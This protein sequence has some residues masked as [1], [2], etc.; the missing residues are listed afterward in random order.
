MTYF[1]LGHKL[2]SVPPVTRPVALIAAV[3]SAILADVLTLFFI[4]QIGWPVGRPQL[5]RAAAGV[6]AYVVLF[7][8]AVL[9]GHLF[10]PAFDAARESMDQSGS[11]LGAGDDS[12]LARRVMIWAV[13][14][15]A[16]SML[17]FLRYAAVAGAARRA[18]RKFLAGES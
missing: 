15:L 18:V 16:G 2:G 13:I 11:P 5:Q 7:P 8:A 6:F 17:F 3:P 1:D 4:G 14:V 9:I 10:Y 12:D